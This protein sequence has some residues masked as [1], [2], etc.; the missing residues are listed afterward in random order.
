MSV[1]GKECGELCADIFH[2]FICCKILLCC[3]WD[4]TPMLLLLGHGAV[5]EDQGKSSVRLLSEIC[6]P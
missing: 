2:E 1:T 5:L 4:L 3:S 6:L